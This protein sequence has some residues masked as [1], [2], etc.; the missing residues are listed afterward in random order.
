MKKI[1][2]GNDFIL[3][4]ILYKVDNQLVLD[5]DGNPVSGTPE[6]LT[7]VKNLTLKLYNLK[8]RKQYELNPVISQNILQ[9]E[10]LIK[11]QQVCK[12]YVLLEYDQD[13][14]YF[15]SGFQH[16]KVGLYAFEMFPQSSNEEL[17]DYV[18]LY[19]VVSSGSGDIDLTG[20]VTDEELSTQLQSYA[21]KTEVPDISNLAT[22]DEIPSLDGYAL[23]DNIPDITNLATKD[24]VNLKVDKITGKGLS[25]NDYTT[26]EKSKLQGISNNANYYVHPTTHSADIIVDG[27]T[28]KAYTAIEKTKLSG[29]SANAD[30]SVNSDWNAI[31]GKAQI[32][33]K[34]TTIVGYGINDVYSKDQI[35]TQLSDKEPLIVPGTS[36]QYFRGDKTWQIL[37][38]SSIGL[39]NVDNTSDENKPISLAAQIEF[40]SKANLQHSHLPEDISQTIPVSKGGT[41][42]SSIGSANQVLK[43]NNDGTALEYATTSEGSAGTVSS[44]NLSMPN[45]FVVYNN[46]ITTNG[47]IQVEMTN[48]YSIPLTSKQNNWDSAYSWGNHEGLYRPISYIPNWDDV[49]SKPTTLSGYGITDAQS[50]DANLTAIIGLSGT[51]GLLKKTAANTW[52]LDTN[53][54]LTANQNITISGDVSGSGTNFI[55]L[56]LNTVSI[57][58]GGT[59]L[60]ALGTANQLL[61]VNSGAT[62]LE[63][64]TPDF[65]GGTGTVTSVSMTVPT[66]LTV[67]GSPIVNSGTLALSF[68][69]GYSIPTII[70]QNTWD[71]AYGWGNHSGLYQLLDADLTSIAGL[72]GTSGLLKKTAAN[73]WSL[74]TNTYLTGNQSITLT[75]AVTGSGTTTITT[76]YNTTV[77][78][79]KG[80]T[81]LTSIGTAGQYLAVNS[82]GTSLE[83]ITSRDKGVNTVS[84][85]TS[86]PTSKRLISA[87]ITSNTAISLAST[88]EVGDEL[89]IIVYNNS[90]STVS[91]ALPNSGSFISLSGTSINIPSYSR[92]EVN[93]LCYV[94]G[95]YLIRAL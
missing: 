31:S 29:I 37:N 91:Q 57:N 17:V 63:Y 22:K 86:L 58:K 42:L 16:L 1:R 44:V 4:L 43:V 53:L 77:P 76:S 21:L 54:Y 55:N 47:T 73:T 49:T 33:N 23:V 85:L 7:T 19:S 74:D 46:P 39:Q 87:T 75:G 79:T 62:G 51:S 6:D 84:S 88:L 10:I 32:L 11:I 93:I 30:V 90:G 28:N 56:T 59:G 52:S 83:W 35:N 36:T 67:S 14:E 71:T 66:G 65:G 26:E 25:T 78:T 34:P 50:S 41:G 40:N 24:S 5:A 9:D 38:K 64:F 60:T 27:T 48:G 95:S 82:G 81:G 61:R 8:Y 13:N 94:S 80:G 15:E 69:E 2:L 70:K 12:H 3:K 92:I 68:S 72:A 20:Y 89:H 18:T 45:Y